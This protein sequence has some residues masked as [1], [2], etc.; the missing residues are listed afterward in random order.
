MKVTT[1]KKIIFLF[2]LI[3]GIEF[4]IYSYGP[5]LRGDEAAYCYV[6]DW[7]HN[8]PGLGY[9]IGNDKQRIETI[10]DIINSQ[11]DHY[12]HH[13]GRSIVHAV[14]Q[15][16]SG[17]ST[18]GIFYVVN[19]FVLLLTITLIVSISV[20]K[21][22]MTTA[23]SPWLCT[24]I[25]MVYLLP[26]SLYILSSINLA[27]NYL[28]PMTGLLIV[29]AIWRYVRNH[30]KQYS[31]ILC[32]AIGLIS[33]I[34]GWSHEAYCLALS[35]SFFLYY[36]FN[37][38][39][40]RGAQVW[41]VAG[42]W[43]GT[44]IM[45]MAPGNFLRLHRTESDQRIEHLILEFL[46]ALPRLK[47]VYIFL[48]ALLYFRIKRKVD[49]Q[50]FVQH[51]RLLIIT[52][53]L[54]LLFICFVH[55]VSQSFTGIE[56][57]S[58]LMFMS[59]CKP[60]FT[61]R[62]N[63]LTGILMIIV[64]VHVGVISIYEFRQN[65]SE[66]EAMERYATSPDGLAVNYTRECENPIVSPWLRH[67]M[68]NFRFYPLVENIYANNPNRLV[69]ITPEDESI[70]KEPEKYFKPEYLFGSGPFYAVNGCSK[71]WA[72]ADSSLLDKS[73]LWHF[74]KPKWSE[75]MSMNDRVNSIINPDAVSKT[76]P[77]AT[78]E[79]INTAHGRFTIINI[80]TERKIIG[81]SVADNN[82]SLRE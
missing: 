7:E 45:F 60:I 68:D 62:R 80:P 63:N 75:Q 76:M 70:I 5:V 18:P 12:K 26:W 53:I 9:G 2:L 1:T 32:L 34:A 33:F 82:L 28:W 77:T 72:P 78:P 50:N 21:R 3:L 11:I 73:Y 46:L 74:D 29:L 23:L 49:Y 71:V 81:L 19:T 41:I 16:F 37:I 43:L 79:I 10:G 20:G 69:L 51:N 56:L 64:C 39:E 66:R 58:I 30:N 36:I 38:K 67:P 44:L 22:K 35:G 17:V 25:G 13:G 65:K 57:L 48:I 61:G 27:C 24:A 6:L 31:L 14:E 40:L 15:F 47:C 8:G 54:A 42:Y 59:L 55:T 52:W 4:Y